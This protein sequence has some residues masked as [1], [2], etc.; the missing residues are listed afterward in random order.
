MLWCQLAVRAPQQPLWWRP[1]QKVAMCR[2]SHS[3]QP[4]SLRRDVIIPRL[5]RGLRRAVTFPQPWGS[6]NCRT[7]CQV[8]L[9]AEVWAYPRRSTHLVVARARKMTPPLMPEAKPSSKGQSWLHHTGQPRTGKY[10]G[11]N[12]C[13]PNNQRTCVAIWKNNLWPITIMCK[14]HSLQE[15]QGEH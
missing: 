10:L 15:L 9:T 13:R 7:W 3:A 14:K 4:Q 12:Q 1:M 11:G 2:P 8:D 6:P 5:A